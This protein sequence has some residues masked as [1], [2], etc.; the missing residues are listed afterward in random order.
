MSDWL[1]IN[2]SLL[3]SPKLKK[4]ALLLGVDDD[5]ALGCAVR[6]LMFIDEQ[7]TDGNTE[8]EPAIIDSVLGREGAA[9]ALMSIGWAVLN[10]SHCMCATDYEKHCGATAK[11]R[12]EDARRKALSRSRSRNK[13]RPQNVRKMSQKNVTRK[14]NNIPKGILYSASCATAD[15]AQHGTMEKAPLTEEELSALEAEADAEWQAVM[16]A[17]DTPNAEH[18]HE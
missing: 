4:L 5:T 16:Q 2:H 18:A 6:W 12:A 11:R 8:L 13:T 3:R 10:M 17:L 9:E 7:T 15:A 14:E 1:K